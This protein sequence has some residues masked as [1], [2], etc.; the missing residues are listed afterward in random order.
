MAK[1]QTKKEKKNYKALLE[2]VDEF[3]KRDDVLFA[4]YAIGDGD[5][6]EKEGGALFVGDDNDEYVIGDGIYQ[7]LKNG[8]AKDASMRQ[9][10]VAYAITYGLDQL[11]KECSLESCVL[12][13]LI[14]DSISDVLKKHDGF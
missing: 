10:K 12:S 4:I 2:L 3:K 6:D 5:N 13:N 7:L 11:F 14:C 1:K 9:R 8:L